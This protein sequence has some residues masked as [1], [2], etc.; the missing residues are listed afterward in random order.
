M[1][2]IMKRAAVICM[3]F[4]MMLTMMPF[5]ALTVNAKQLDS[6]TIGGFGFELW[7]DRDDGS[8]IGVGSVNITGYSGTSK[9]I[10]IPTKVTTQGVTFTADPSYFAINSNAF[11]RKD[12]IKVAIPSTIAGIGS[13]AFS[14]CTSLIE[15]SIGSLLDYGPWEGIGA[16]AFTGCTSLKT[17]NIDSSGM[18]AAKNNGSV[19]LEDLYNQ[20]INA[21]I[22]TDAS[23]NPIAGVTVYTQNG[24]TVWKAIEKLNE[25]RPEGKKINLVPSNDPY[26]RNTISP[27]AG[28]SGSGMGEDGTAY[29]PGASESVVDKAIT[30]YSKE[31]DP[32]GSVFGLLKARVTKTTKTSL[33]LTW[34][35]VSGAKKYI[36]YG[37]QCGSKY[38]MVRQKV[39]KSSKKSKAVFKKISKKKVKKGK[40]YKFIVVAI[41]KNGKVLSTSK[42]VHATTK[43][44]TKWVN[45]KSVTTKAKKNKVKI[46]KGKKFKLAGKTVAEKGKGKLIDHRKIVYE[47]S[48][49]KVATVTKKGVIKGVGKGKCTIYVYAHNGVFKAIK[50]TVN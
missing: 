12:I 28:G 39:V 37:S 9:E 15:V 43:G 36:I 47:S 3:A 42:M 44:G 25:T 7:D 49:P 4:V 21:G 41:D 33:T 40:P 19:S 20:I 6:T 50:V 8:G 35:K 5:A 2:K 34:D 32:K 48:N 17:Y 45:A 46:S 26:G 23:G 10:V 38:K 16:G 31:T 30:K 18:D 13:G 11:K 14:E 22:G 29:G 24:S 1:R 27:A